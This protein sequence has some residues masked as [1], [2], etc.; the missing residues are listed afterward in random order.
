M[1]K[2]YLAVLLLRLLDIMKTDEAVSN[3]L[4]VV[5]L[6]SPQK[7]ILFEKLCQAATKYERHVHYPDVHYLTVD[8]NGKQELLEFT[9]PGLAHTGGREMAIRRADLA[10][11]FYSALSLNSLHHLQA[12]EEDL[13]FKKNLPLRLVCDSD[14]VV[15]DEEDGEST[16]ISS[17]SEG[18]ESDPEREG[19]I[20]RRNSMDKIRK[21]HEDG[22][23]AVEQVCA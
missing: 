13:A 10:L 11:L 6:G 22:G 21:A 16:G 2:H 8:C 12:L 20:R 14:E 7:N 3:E 18:Y 23:M 17:V 19:R 5:M 1:A 15:E 9:D 4:N